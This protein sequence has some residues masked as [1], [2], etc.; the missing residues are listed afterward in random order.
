MKNYRSMS[1]GCGVELPKREPVLDFTEEGVYSK[2][3]HKGFLL[4][5]FQSV[6]KLK[7]V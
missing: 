2:E 4:N 5:L 7:I 3:N 6:S 1:I